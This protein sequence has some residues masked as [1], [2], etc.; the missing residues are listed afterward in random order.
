MESVIQYQKS[1]IRFF[2]QIPVVCVYVVVIVVAVVWLC[3]GIIDTKNSLM[4]YIGRHKLIIQWLF[5]L[6]YGGV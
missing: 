4:A 5:G 6:E 1:A 2:K 3:E